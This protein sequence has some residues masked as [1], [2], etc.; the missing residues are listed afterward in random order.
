M[1]SDGDVLAGNTKRILAGIVE[2]LTEHGSGGGVLCSREQAEKLH[3]RVLELF[4]EHAARMSKRRS[5]LYRGCST[6]YGADGELDVNGR[7]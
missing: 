4:D 7:S 3:Q 6:L 1:S 5:I 2:Q